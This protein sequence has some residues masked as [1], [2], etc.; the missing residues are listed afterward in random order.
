MGLDLDLDPNIVQHLTKMDSTQTNW[1][2]HIKN[3]I[4]ISTKLNQS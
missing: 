2:D 4:E 3:S 1:R